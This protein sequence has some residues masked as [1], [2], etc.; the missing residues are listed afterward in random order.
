MNTVSGVILAAGRSRRL[1]QPKQ[2]LE[3]GGEPLL[4]HTVR[5]ALASRLSEVVLVLGAE[6]AKIEGAVGALGQRIV[7]N[8]IHHLGQSTS[9][10]LGLDSIDPGAGAVVFLLGDQPGVTPVIIDALIE[11][12]NETCAPIVQARYANGPGNP[13]LLRR[14]LF[15][16]LM[17]VAGDEGARSVVYR[18]RDEIAFA[19]FA[20]QDV[21]CDVDTLDDYEALLA[22]WRAP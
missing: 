16:E 18:H 6:A 14:S 13:V 5:S 15:P 21:P 3:L 4:R 8:P 1:G 11:R 22:S 20:E 12:C 17:T 19:T 7:V 2:L 9:L 10:R